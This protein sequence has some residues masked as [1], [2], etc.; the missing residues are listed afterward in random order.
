MNARDLFDAVLLALACGAIGAIGL[1]QILM[2]MI[3]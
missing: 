2:G 1:I 3:V